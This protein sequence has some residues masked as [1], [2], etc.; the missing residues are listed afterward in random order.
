MFCSNL[1]IYLID[2]LCFTQEYLTYTTAG[3]TVVGGDR[4]V[5]EETAT[6]LRLLRDIP[7][8]SRRGSQYE[9]NLTS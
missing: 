7:T 9:L 3:S 8:Y 6:I 1:S 5:P 2:V 4:E